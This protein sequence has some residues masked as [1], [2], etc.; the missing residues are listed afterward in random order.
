VPITGKRE[1]NILL[2]AYKPRIEERDIFGKEPG[3]VE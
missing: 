2:L 3:A 1:K